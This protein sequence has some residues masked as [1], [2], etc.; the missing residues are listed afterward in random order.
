MVKFNEDTRVK[1]PSILHL[2]RLGY[3]YLSL[4]DANW[5][6]DSNIFTD[7][8]KESI[9]KINKDNKNL[10]IKRLQNE[11]LELIDYEDMGKAFYERLLSDSNI[12]IVDF[13][14]FSNNSFHVVTELTYK[15]D[16]EEFRPDI[17]LLINGIPLIFLEVKK[18]NNE[19]GILAERDRI[20]KRFSNKKFR[21][22]FN[23]TQL[24]IFSNN[25]EYDD[26]AIEP[27]EGAFYATPAPRPQFNYF[28][29]EEKLNIAQILKDEDDL[30]ETYVLKD[31]NYH[32]IK[33]NKEFQTNKNYNTPTNRL[34]TSLFEKNRLAFLL[35]YAIAYVKT[36]EGFEK[37]IMRYPQFFATKAISTKLDKGLK[38]GIIWH[39]QG[40]GK[41]ALAFYNVRYL[42]DY[43]QSKNVIPKFYFIVDRIDLLEQAQ[44][45]F[46]SRGLKVHIIN[47]RD[48]FAKDIKKTTAIHNDMGKLEITVVNIQRFEDDPSIIETKDY[49]ISIQR[50]FFLDEVHRSY[51][52]TGKFLVNLMKADEK[53]IKI[54]LTGTPLLGDKYN[55][56]SLFGDY[57]HKYYYNK[58]IADG[59]T[60]RLIRE[61]IETS[62]KIQLQKTLEELEI[63]KGDLKSKDV[64]AHHSFVEPML[65]YIISDFE[66]ARLLLGDNTIG[67]MVICNSSEQAKMMFDIFQDKFAQIDSKNNLEYF[68]ET[69][70][71]IDYKNKKKVSSKVKTA[72]LIL[73]DVETKQERKQKILDFKEGRIDFL[74]VFNMLLTGFD[75]KR[76]KKLYLGRV[77]REHGLLQALTRV[78]RTYKNFRYGYVVDFAD[79]TKEFDATNKAYFEELQNELGDEMEYYSSLF[80]SKE[81]I[82][83]EIEEI[84]EVLFNYD[85]L[86]AENFRKQIDQIDDIK[87]MQDLKRVLTNTK[88]IYN[89]IK[90]F[91]HEEMLEQLDFPKLSLL[92]KEVSNHLNI[93]HQREILLKGDESSNL[94]NIALE[95]IIFKFTK[96]S[97][98]ELVL[99]DELKDTLRKAREA[100]ENNFD[101][102][103]PQ[104]ITLKEELERLFKGKNLNEVTQDE[105]NQNISILKKI[106]KKISQLNSENEQLRD[107][108][109]RDSKYARIHKRLYEKG[110]ITKKQTLLFSAL[111]AVKVRLDEKVLNNSAILKNEKFFTIETEPII[112]E[113][114]EDNYK[115]ELN[116]DSFNYINHLVVNE[117]LNEY[118]GVVNW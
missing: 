71:T 15:N 115:I 82:L 61:E 90:L 26:T 92:Y 42:T 25:M 112:D 51:K 110:T 47:S 49:D 28:R 70:S 108:Y 41:T 29:E 3:E 52:P 117:Y 76:L 98:E 17:T 59:Y 2:V 114:F 63:Q 34:C 104:F 74:F 19:K 54:G 10:D 113:E 36:K 106:H 93:L 77:I 100:L 33:G 102:N 43:Y 12:K 44:D 75:A 68:V 105:M 32:V 62:Y 72:A 69:Q 107:K 85:T 8:F 6:K 39:T 22:F 91:G 50:I 64:F 53:A 5:D 11:I 1:I 97:E 13:E 88:E 116:E 101:K 40:S 109:Q 103:D 20:Y 57:I 95:D 79:I 81:E 21:K 18:P 118:N 38:K 27:L 37:H 86:D 56:R 83:N 31:L 24:M 65:D 60:L 73:H 111:E 46:T 48:E 96:L 58:S 99:A 67:G 23:I 87:K 45:E 66:K 14:N 94:L 84:R 4:K 78:N 7:I 55:S 9:Q 16:D 35:R 89:M 80:K 30:L